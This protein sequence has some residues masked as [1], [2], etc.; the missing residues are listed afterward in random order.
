MRG[1]EGKEVWAAN[2]KERIDNS[3]AG[4]DACTPDRLWS[5]T[6]SIKTDAIPLE[7]RTL[8]RCICPTAAEARVLQNQRLAEIGWD[9]YQSPK[10]LHLDA[11]PRVV[12]GGGS[13]GRSGS[14]GRREMSSSLPP[15]LPPPLLS[16]PCL[17][18][19]DPVDIGA[20]VVD[21]PAPP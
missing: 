6:S 16:S 2:E 12:E 3:K 14:R 5:L 15:P 8:G 4:V 13:G 11:V 10:L 21:S 1:G 18:A 9:R 19:S 20:D 17:S 7:E